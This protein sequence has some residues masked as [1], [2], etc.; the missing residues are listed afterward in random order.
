MGKEGPDNIELQ[1]GVLL[2]IID[3]ASLIVHLPH[4]VSRCQKRYS[5]LG[6]R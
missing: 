6:S 5:F 3:K 2:V 4:N 1:Q